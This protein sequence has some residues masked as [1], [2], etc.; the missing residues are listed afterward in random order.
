MKKDIIK[1]AATSS[2]TAPT[3]IFLVHGFN[4]RDE[5]ANSIDRLIPYITTKHGRIEQFDYGWTG[6]IDIL[7][8]NKKYAS[9]LA[10]LQAKTYCHEGLAIGH[11]NG[12]AIVCEAARQ[13]AKFKRVLLINP[14]MP[15]DYKFSDN[16]GEVLVVYTKHDLPTKAA[17][18]GNRI[19]FL[20]W[21]VP[22]AWGA[23][24][25]MGAK[26]A[27]LNFDM[28]DTIKGHSDIFTNVN[29][30]VWGNF[31]IEQLTTDLSYFHRVNMFIT[32]NMYAKQVRD[33]G[34]DYL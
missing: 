15:V 22:D 28:S 14:A 29:M 6:M 9:Q 20:R 17:R 24:G 32:N 13:G 33:F 31:L 18:W 16:I 2:N 11:S 5:G 4:V 21:F 7:R 10:K 1:G 25:A 26:N 34:E 3:P 23:M 8:N 12:C 27:A 30:H 19:P